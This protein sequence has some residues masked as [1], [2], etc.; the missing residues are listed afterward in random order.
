VLLQRGQVDVRRRFTLA[1]EL[2]HVLLP[3]HVGDAFLCDTGRIRVFESTHEFDA[4]NTEPEANRFAGNL[5]VPDRWLETCL[6]SQGADEIAPLM[7]A[8]EDA[9][10]SAYVAC[11][12]LQSVL[13]AGHAFAIT[14]GG[15]LQMRG[16]TQ[17]T[18]VLP[19]DADQ[20]LDVARLN[21]W[22]HRVEK[23]PY[24]PNRVTWWTFRGA[25]L[26][27]DHAADPRAWREV[28]EGLLDL[29]APAQPDRGRMQGSLNGVIAAAHGEARREGRVDAAELYVR[30]RG[31]FAKARDLPD[32]LL[33][34][35]E[36]DL[37]LHKRAEDFA[38]R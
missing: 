33:E 29:H 22:A 6:A 31:R 13:P 38:A 16:Q 12:R 25:E 37:L 8:L 19:H 23:I 15:A 1:H 35:P 32:A 27:A 34:D 18:G 21:R 11:L 28:L 26:V 36:F 9:Q 4:A 7:S 5:L 17:G 3:W 20:D 14:Q 10:V 24:G 2:G 30:F